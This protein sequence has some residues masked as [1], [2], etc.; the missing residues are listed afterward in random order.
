MEAWWILSQYS[1]WGQ[2]SGE[3]PPMLKQAAG[4]A[5]LISPFIVIAI[6]NRWRRR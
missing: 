5:I 4:L 6:L 3:S 2:G 1:G